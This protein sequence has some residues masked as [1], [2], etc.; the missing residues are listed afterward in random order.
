MV[1]PE[2]RQRYGLPDEVPEDIQAALAASVKAPKR[3]LGGLCSGSGCG[4]LT[5]GGVCWGPMASLPSS[6]KGPSAGW[7]AR[8]RLIERGL[9]CRPCYW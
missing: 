8:G 7:V 4:W 1:K 9:L 6:V 2:L 3:K 5:V